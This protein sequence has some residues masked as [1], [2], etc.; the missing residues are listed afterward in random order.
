MKCATDLERLLRASIDLEVHRKYI[1][2]LEKE[3]KKLR[4]ALGLRLLLDDIRR[5]VRAA[6][7]QQLALGSKHE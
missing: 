1:A 3:N 7:A 2:H 6:R 5:D 4:R